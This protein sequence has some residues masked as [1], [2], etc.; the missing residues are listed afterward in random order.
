MIKYLKKIFFIA[1]RMKGQLPLML[2]LT[3][4]ALIL[5]LVG[6]SLII[7][8]LAVLQNPARLETYD[9]WV[10]FSD[11]VG[12]QTHI[13]ALL[14]LSGVLFAVFL[15]KT[16]LNVATQK[17]I[18]DF[19]YDLQTYLRDR[20]SALFLAAP[21]LYHTK[22]RSNDILNIMQSHISQFSKAVVGSLL[23]ITGESI[24]ICIVLAYLLLSYPVPTVTAMI[25]L[26]SFGFF[27]DFTLRRRL[28]KAGAELINANS[29]MVR[30]IREGILSIKEARVLGCGD[31]F[32]HEVANSARRASEINAYVAFV[33]MLPRYV[34]ELLILAVVIASALFM[35]VQDGNGTALIDS[36]AVFAVA[37]VRLLPSANQIVSNIGNLRYSYKTIDDLYAEMKE[38][39][40]YKPAARMIES[41]HPAFETLSLKN[42]SFAYPDSDKKVLDE[43]D[44]EIKKGE[45][46]GISGASGAGKSTVVNIILGL[47]EPSGGEITLNGKNVSA[48]EWSGHNYAAYIPQK[49]TILDASISRNIALGDADVDRDKIWAALD[50]AQLKDLVSTLPELENSAVGEDAAFLSGGQRQRLAV[51]R[52][53]YFSREIL[54]FDEATSALDKDTEKEVLE[55]IKDLGRNAAVLIIAHNEQSLQICD[56]ICYLSG[57]KF[58]KSTS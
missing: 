25:I 12:I 47:L 14:W 57:G 43:L 37:S 19:S 10:S 56:R 27:Y 4:L 53:F 46:I 44:L 13:Q 6:L 17:L 11:A 52:A 36:L 30:A 1:G 9:L 54:I 29:D 33:Q 55:A 3:M 7:P 26:I 20:F 5:E 38:L 2:F 45:I 51:A 22:R 35:L 39:D 42:L 58:I 41:A 34:L 21:Y 40:S 24:T 16:V 49:P 8:F 48:G 18:L 23:R 32:Q 15:I 28:K 50:K 31:Y